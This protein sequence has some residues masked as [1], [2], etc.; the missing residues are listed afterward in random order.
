MRCLDCCSPDLLAARWPALSPGY[1][2]K[3][4]CFGLRIRLVLVH[5]YVE[6]VW[7]GKQLYQQF[8][9]SKSEVHSL[10]QTQKNSTVRDNGVPP[11]HMTN[12]KTGQGKRC[13]MSSVTKQVT[14]F[15]CQP[16]P[17]TLDRKEFEDLIF[18]M[19]VSL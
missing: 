8:F 4:I 5:L 2:V 3:C 15:E 12:E 6:L 18:L 17:N 13:D 7:G 16:G 10:E 19:L 11:P 9:K 14:Q 1:R